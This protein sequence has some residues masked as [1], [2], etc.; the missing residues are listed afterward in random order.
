ML[1]S[2]EALTCACDAVTSAGQQHRRSRGCGALQEEQLLNPSLVLGS[3][4]CET[5]AAL[6][7]VDVPH[8]D[9]ALIVPGGKHEGG[10]VGH[11]LHILPAAASMRIV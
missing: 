6:A 8:K 3:V 10:H 5:A 4:V 2:W 9:A 11:A 7:G 1:L